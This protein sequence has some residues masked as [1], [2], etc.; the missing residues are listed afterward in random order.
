MTRFWRTCGHHVVAPIG[1]AFLFGT[2]TF[3]RTGSGFEN[4]PDNLAAPLITAFLIWLVMLPVTEMTNRAIPAGNVPLLGRLILASVIGAFPLTILLPLVLRV[5]GIDLPGD[6]PLLSTM[7]QETAALERY[8]KVLILVV[9]V[10]CLVNYRWYQQHENPPG[11]DFA[12]ALPPASTPENPP[13]K[14]APPPLPTEPPEPAFL[15]RMVKPIGRQVWAIKA[16]QHYIRIFT[17]EGDELIL[18]RFG[19]ALREL[20]DHEGLQVHRSFWVAKPAIQD[21][22]KDGNSLEIRMH[23]G[24]TVPVSRSFKARLKEEGWLPD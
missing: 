18:Y 19:D 21:I 20:S 7:A 23:N 14:P 9:L 16:E 4:L 17:A 12:S 6:E 15:D 24:E 11:S 2:I 3:L 8:G 13:Q 22:A 1:L 5:F 10:W